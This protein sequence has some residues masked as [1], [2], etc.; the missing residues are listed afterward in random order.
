MLVRPNSVRISALLTLVAVVVAGCAEDRYR[1]NLAHAYVTPWTHLS[2]SD[3]EQI[4]RLVSHATPQPIRGITT[5]RKRGDQNKIHV[6]TAYADNSI[7]DHCT[8][9]EVEKI[10]GKWRITFQGSSSDT[11]AGLVLSGSL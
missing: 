3:L 4:V 1:W 9:F 5:Y 7:A 2:Q 10:G 11:V 8:G 6:I